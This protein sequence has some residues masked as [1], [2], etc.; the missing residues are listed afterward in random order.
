MLESDLGNG[1]KRMREM[2][3]DRDRKWE[4]ERDAK[5]TSQVNR[6]FA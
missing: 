5:G 4:R 6:P 1:E 3:G 2:V